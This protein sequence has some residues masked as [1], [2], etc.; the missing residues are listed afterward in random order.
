MFAR[1]CQTNMISLNAARIRPLDSQINPTSTNVSFANDFGRRISRIPC[2]CRSSAS[3]LYGG[4]KQ[5]V[6][7]HALYFGKFPM[8]CQTT[9]ALSRLL[10]MIHVPA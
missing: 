3:Y 6:V 9:G 5:Y 8:P 2:H 1:V 7:T 4:D 10:D